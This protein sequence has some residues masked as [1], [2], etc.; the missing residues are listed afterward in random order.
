MRRTELEP[1]PKMHL[2]KESFQAVVGFSPVWEG[3]EVCTSLSVRP[4]LPSSSAGAFNHPKP[5]GTPL[6]HGGFARSG[7]G[8]CSGEEKKG[9]KGVC[10]ETSWPCAG[11]RGDRG[12]GF[13]A[14]M[15]VAGPPVPRLRRSLSCPSSR[16]LLPPELPRGR[17]DAV[18]CSGEPEDRFLL[19]DPSSA[20]HPWSKNGYEKA[21]KKKSHLPKTP[22]CRVPVINLSGLILTTLGQELL[23]I[24][25]EVCTG[26]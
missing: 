2:R 22:W 11:G 10:P 6:R 15:E 18:G 7:T 21:K 23:W 12:G 20:S 14:P 9:Q 26:H 25:L 13:V 5:R 4:C 16:G 24:L 1:P 8:S 3:A 17:M 19:L